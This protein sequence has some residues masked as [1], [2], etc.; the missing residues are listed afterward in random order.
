MHSGSEA[1]HGAP[2]AARSDVVGIDYR[3]NRNSIAR[4]SSE[5]GA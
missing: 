2:A 1:N 3:A 4:V 5:S